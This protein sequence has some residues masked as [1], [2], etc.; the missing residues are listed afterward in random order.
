MEQNE[1]LKRIDELEREIALF[2]GGS[3]TVKKIK[4]KEYFYHASAKTANA[5]KSMSN[6]ESYN[7]KFVDTTVPVYKGGEQVTFKMVR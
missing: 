7:E 6:V 1:L 5:G 3:M 2:P 4:D